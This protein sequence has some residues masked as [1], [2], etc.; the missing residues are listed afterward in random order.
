M[1]A[2]RLHVVALGLNTKS[3]FEET[4]EL[5]NR[6]TR[7]LPE[8]PA[9]CSLRSPLS[10]VGHEEH[11]RRPRVSSRLDY[12][13]EIALVIGSSRRYLPVE[14]A[15]EAVAGVTRANDGS[16]RLTSNGTPTRS[17]PERTSRRAERSGRG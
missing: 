3:H 1:S 7:R 15:L 2:S 8:V 13:G 6:D 10:V 5:M 16:I 17:P 11:I 9:P 12:E 14:D 4:A